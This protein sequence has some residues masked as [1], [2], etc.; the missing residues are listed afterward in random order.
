[1]PAGFYSC[2]GSVR[3]GVSHMVNTKGFLCPCAWAW[4]STQSKG[5]G[6]YQIRHVLSLL[7]AEEHKHK[8]V[9]SQLCFSSEMCNKAFV[10]EG[11]I[12]SAVVVKWICVWVAVT[13][14]DSVSLIVEDTGE[15][16]IGV[17]LQNLQA[18]SRLNIPQTS[19]FVWAGSQDP[20]ALRAKTD[21][22]RE[23]GD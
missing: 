3:V 23:A 10:T 11:Y 17:A 4:A 21:L 15:D 6:Q 14:N 13:C 9:A 2:H 22:P 16:L 7:P 18:D 8:Q 12:S 19:C 5:N 1:M 20:P